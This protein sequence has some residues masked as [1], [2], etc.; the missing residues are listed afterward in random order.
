MDLKELLGEELYGQVMTK[1]GENKIA[2]VSDGNWFPK[3]KFDDVNNSNKDLKAQL[4]D[5][6]KQLADLGDKAKGNEDLTK[7]IADLTE[8][9]KKAA[10]DYE[11]K[12]QGQAFDFALKSALTGAKAKNPKAVEALLNRENLKLDGEK[13]VGLDDQLKTIQES[14]PYLFDIEEEK[15]GPRFTT[16]QHKSGGTS[17]SFA[18]VLL[19]EQNKN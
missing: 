9:N 1:A 18:S 13:L 6:D 4:K 19:G 11:A 15:G 3:E 2:I 17:D 14:D 16:G 7:Q 12:L 8:A 10:A 5:R